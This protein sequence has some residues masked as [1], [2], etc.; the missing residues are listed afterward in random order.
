[1]SFKPIFSILIAGLFLGCVSKEEEMLMSDFDRQ[2]H[3][4]KQI[5]QTQQVT[6]V[7]NDKVSALISALYLY[8]KSDPL[9]PRK[10]EKFII[11]IYSDDDIVPNVLLNG[12]DA[13]NITKLENNDSRLADIPLKN[14]W[15]RY[16]MVSFLPDDSNKMILKVSLDNLGQRELIF[17]K[18]ANLDNIQE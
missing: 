18:A 14:Q 3:H 17:L 11:G 10:Y 16:Y 15:S 9:M 12:K 8:Q 7:Q 13:I 6:I 4:F 1:M 5:Q 2:K